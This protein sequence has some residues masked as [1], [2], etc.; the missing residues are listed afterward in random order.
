V[1]D[2]PSLDMNFV[3]NQ[4][5][6][7]VWEW[8]FFENAG[9]S[10]VPTSVVERLNAYMIESH[11]QPHASY[12]P[13]AL[14]ARRMVEGQ[15]LTA[16]MINAD[17]DEVIVGPNTTANVFV[18]AHALRP[19]FKE[20]DEIVVTNLDHEANS[21][22]WRRMGETGIT[23]REWRFNP[24]T[25]ELEIEALEELL[26]E[27]TRLVCFPHCSNI[28]GGIS[29]AAAIVEKV[30][31]AGAMACVDGVAFAPHRHVDVKALDADFYLFSS[32]KVFG[33]H[34]GILYGKRERLLEARSQNHFFIGEDAVQ[35]KLNPG[36]AN[37]ELTAALVGVA[38]YFEAVYRHHFAAASNSF[39]ERVARA[40][41][42]FS[43]HEETL[44]AR[45]LDFVQS[46]PRVRLY[47]P[48][49]VERAPTFSFSVDG[50]PSA[51]IPPQLEDGRVGIRSGHFYAYR[52]VRDLGLDPEDGVVRVSMAHY[53]SLDEVDR[54]IR[55]LDRV[56]PDGR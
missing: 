11:V 34:L 27:R 49:T 2:T 33:P 46:K 53:N 7:T 19:L 38:D 40:Y 35:A 23:V 54:L 24:D 44:S 56:I 52:L 29:D 32:Y 50:F 17:A 15:R 48:P 21:G 39:G 5:P 25:A 13:S 43:E 36:A 12:A 30:H 37:H 3:R 28:T 22:A 4:F 8:A 6:D 45:F 9:G 31:A 20:G 1:S 47:G 42:L 10:F 18:L 55:G 16:E 26:S 51:T 41:G 14:A